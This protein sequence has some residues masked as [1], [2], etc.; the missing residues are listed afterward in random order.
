MTEGRRAEASVTIPREIIDLLEGAGRVL[1]LTHHNPDGD[2]LGSASALARALLDRGKSCRLYFDGEWLKQL[3][4]LLEGL[5][6][7]L[8]PRSGDYDLA[9]ILDCHGYE[10]LGPAGPALAEEL[11]SLPLV[12]IDHHLLNETEKS[13]GLWLHRPEISSTGELVWNLL[14]ALNWRPDRAAAQGLLLAIASD[15]GF[16]GQSNTGADTLRSA[17]DLL[18][19][20]GDL[21]EIKRQVMHNQPLKRLKLMGLALG[22]L[23]LHCGGRLAVMLVTPAML[24]EAGAEMSDTEN[25]I[26]LGRSLS[27]VDLVALV[28]DA[29][30]G[31]GRVRVS[32]RSRKGVDARALAQTFGGGGHRRAAAY[33]DL[34]AGNAEEA[35][36]R[37][38]SRAAQ[39]L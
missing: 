8:A 33:T 36:L 26:E 2:A 29:G 18:D 20:G 25:F 13:G 14:T 34:E 24:A 7:D 37:L 10:R 23:A 28:K 4:F 31:P 12:V 35:L 32:L 21:E 38:L 39:Y 17:A 16:F 3:E 1:L 9:V 19:L 22:T 30:G 5:E 15:T 6:R 11:Q 27:G